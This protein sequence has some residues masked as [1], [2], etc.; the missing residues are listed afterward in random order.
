MSERLILRS[1]LFVP[2]DNQK[3]LSK[4]ASLGAD[5]VV[6]DLEDAVVESRKAKA[7]QMVSEH[8]QVADRSV[9]QHWV[10]INA[11]DTEHALDDLSM[12]MAG[13]PDGIFLPKAEHA[14]DG[15]RL[16]AHISELESEYSIE[17]GST[18]ILLVAIETA[19]SILTIGS[20]TAVHPRVCGLTWGAVDL[21]ASIGA[22]S[23]TDD[24]GHLTAPY[25]HAR[26]MTLVAA[27]ASGVQAVDTAFLDFKDDAGLRQNCLEARRDG[28]LGKIAIHPAQVGP[29]NEAFMPTPEEIEHAKAVVKV[30]ADNPH[31]GTVSLNGRMLDKPH[32][33]QAQRTLSLAKQYA[34]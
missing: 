33:L 16:A 31:A 21:S 4:S 19:K 18:Q 26:T 11:L 6:F 13:R 1:W 29:I 9:C 8:L 7:R 10:R 28:F 23:N 2:G 34:D 20:Y 12:V 22:I 15:D 5:A 17:S 3:M 30:F 25:I 32:L 27:G 14:E 24:Q